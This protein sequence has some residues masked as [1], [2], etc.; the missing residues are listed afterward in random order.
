MGGGG[1]PGGAGRLLIAMI[2]SL[3]W[4]TWCSPPLPTFSCLE[5]PGGAVSWRC[6]L[7]WETTSCAAKLL[8]LP[9]EVAC[10]S[11]GSGSEGSSSGGGGGGGSY[12]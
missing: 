2:W 1:V 5:A 3:D 10:N 9:V 12:G 6:S 7:R 11:S 8:G 4:C